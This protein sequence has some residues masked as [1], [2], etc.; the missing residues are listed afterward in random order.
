[1][2]TRIKHKEEGRKLFQIEIPLDTIER[3]AEEVYG[4][5]KKAAKIPGF[6][7]GFAPRDLLEKHYSKNAEDEILKRLVPEGYRKALENHKITPIGVPQISNINFQKEKHLTFE[8]EVDV[9]PDI[10]LKNYKGIK[11]AKRRI[12]VSQEEINETIS[13]VR[14]IYAN[15]KDVEGPVKKGDYAVCD[16]EAFVNSKPVTKKN[17][18]M[19]VLADKE[20]SLL[21]MGEKLIGLEKGEPKEIDAKL[22]EG[23]PDKKYAGKEAKFKILVNAIKEK[24]PPAFDDAFA[25]RLKSETA[26]TLKK[27]IESQLFS[28]KEND[29]KIDMKNQILERL[30]RDNRFSVP[31]GIARRQKEILAKRLE[32]ELLQ[33]GMLKEETDKKLKE[34]D[35]KLEQDARDKVRIYFILDE[36]AKKEKIDVNEKD[37]EK[38]LQA[39]AVSTDRAVG[40]VKKYYEKEKLLDGLAEEEKEN[41]TLELLLKEAQVIEGGNKS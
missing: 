32:T 24:E 17:K 26:E 36:I 38:R 2:K 37:V 40:E 5:I 3:I 34:L 33:K 15:Y 22:P 23:Y 35:S 4:E 13:R 31:A 6:R 21:G 27:E 19:W 28:R 10:R 25:K 30:L 29:L 39:I 11:V 1:M 12:F 20:A 14:N 8:A 16:V 9:K 18:N 41:K 7:V